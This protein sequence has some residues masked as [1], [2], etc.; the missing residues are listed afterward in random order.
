M[1]TFEVLREETRRAFQVNDA[2]ALAL[3]AVELDALQTDEAIAMADNARGQVHTLHGEYEEALDSFQ[4]S[5][6]RYERLGEHR[7]ALLSLANSVNIHRRSGNY[8][9]SIEIL[10]R[11]VDHCEQTGDRASLAV[12]LGNLGV[13]YGEQGDIPESLQYYQR[14]IALHEELGEVV[15]V[16]PLLGNLGILY[17]ELGDL[18]RALQYLQ[19]ALAL[20]TENGIE[21]IALILTSLANVYSGA[22]D[23]ASA[24]IYGERCLELS[25]TMSDRLNQGVAHQVIGNAYRLKGDLDAAL[26][27]YQCALE[28]DRAIGVQSGIMV[29]MI[30]IANVLILRGE[31]DEAVQLLDQLAD[32]PL[33]HPE[34]RAWYFQHRAAVARHRGDLDEAH[35]QLS[36]ALSIVQASGLKNVEIGIHQEMRDLSRLRGDFDAY[37]QHNDAYLRVTEEVRGREALQR[38]I[39]LEAEQTMQAERQEREKERALLYGALPESVAN[40]MLNGDDVS[41][42]HYSSACVI[43]LDIAGFTKISDTVP[44]QLVVY[45]LEQI[46]SALDDVMEVHG[47][48]KIKTIGDSYMAVS[49]PVNGISEENSRTS[50]SESDHVVRAALCAHDMQRVI[51]ELHIAVPPES[52]DTTWVRSVGEINAR[53]GLHCGPVTAGV[54]GTKRLQYDVWGDTV[55][56]ASRMES[57]GEPGRIHVSEAFADTLT[58]C[59]PDSLTL[60]KRSI[61]EVKGK[62]PMTTYWLEGA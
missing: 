36:E 46:F 34:R 52:R 58:P 42:D 35:N 45:L 40:R 20:C 8:A 54:I 13:I 24:I 44:P 26:E 30:N 27:H 29:S 50:T 22:G 62:G 53:I 14:A 2:E 61:T 59:F 16:A 15:R 56:V 10:R 7:F 28:I 33:A 9:R 49:F 19:R 18:P 41:G 38:M 55:N 11:V 47:V 12:M 25:T 21:N 1:R 51:K 4:R 32:M 6:D 31:L 17:R 3:L 60:V 39:A 37:V 5:A 57:H 48:T 43:F 23:H